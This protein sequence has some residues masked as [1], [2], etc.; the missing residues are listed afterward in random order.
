M[1]RTHRRACSDEFPPDMTRASVLHVDE[2]AVTGSSPVFGRRA[3]L[4]LLSAFA[5]SMPAV[6]AT[7]VGVFESI[8]ANGVV[9][10]WAQDPDAPSTAIAVHIYMNAPAGQGGIFVAATVAGYTRQDVGAHGFRYPI[11]PIG[12]DGLPHAFYVYGIDTDGQPGHNVLLSGSPI[13]ATLAST[14]VFISNGTMTVGLEPRCGGTVV[15]IVVSGSENL[16]NNGDCTGKQVQIGLYDGAAMYDGCAGCTGTWGWDPVQGGDRFG[17]GSPVTSSAV[18]ATSAYTLTRPYQWNPSDKGGA[19]GQPV[20]S[21]TT[22]EQWV[23][24]VDGRPN[25]A[26][27]HIKITHVGTD[28][29]VLASQEIPAVYVNIGYDTLV[30]Y[31]GTA[32]WSNATTTNFAITPSGNVAT[33]ERWEAFVNQNN[34]GLAVYM[35]SQHPWFTATRLVGSTGEFGQA[36]NY[37]RTC[38]SNS[39]RMW[40]LRATITCSPATSR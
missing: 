13:N 36:A 9:V 34:F 1:T 20:A 14:R 4:V 30:A 31:I 38:R 11:A 22:L 35:P 27:V 16:V 24:F 2:F 3:L 28:R 17:F 23:T 12:R 21:D 18:T 39:D 10:G 29:H 40:C 19:P 7:P 33:S 6:A 5:I 15:S 32:P 8:D 37:N 25:V 26:K